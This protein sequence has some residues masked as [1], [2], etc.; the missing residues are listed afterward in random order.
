MGW[1]QTFDEISAARC[2]GTIHPAASPP[3][4][5]NWYQVQSGNGEERHGAHTAWLQVHNVSEA[6]TWYKEQL[7]DLPELGCINDDFETQNKTKFE[8][9][10]EALRAF[11][12]ALAPKPCQ[13][14]DS[15]KSRPEKMRFLLRCSKRNED[16]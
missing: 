16:C 5:Y 10:M 4:M 3:W 6:D 2:R 12:N 7:A 9:Q 11:Y 1:P 8:S 15:K 14:E 13:F